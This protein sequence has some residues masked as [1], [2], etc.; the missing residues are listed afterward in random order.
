[1]MLA[2]CKYTYHFELFVMR[3]ERCEAEHSVELVREIPY[4]VPLHV[5]EICYRTEQIKCSI[6][7]SDITDITLFHMTHCGHYYHNECIEQSMFIS[8]NCPICRKRLR[9]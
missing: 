7:L 4:E 6:C 1:L 3:Y 9:N 8:S 2:I 5:K